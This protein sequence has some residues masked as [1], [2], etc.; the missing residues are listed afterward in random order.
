M[1]EEAVHEQM[2]KLRVPRDEGR[3]AFHENSDEGE[4]VDRPSTVC[5]SASIELVLQGLKG[6]IQRETEVLEG[7]AQEEGWAG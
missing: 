5:A 7:V 4:R 3:I 2:G 6:Q 1:A